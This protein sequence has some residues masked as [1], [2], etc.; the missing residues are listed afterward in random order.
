MEERTNLLL[1]MG[2]SPSQ[3]ESLMAG[4]INQR[5][6]HPATESRLSPL[7]Q[8]Q[9][10]HPITCQIIRPQSFQTTQANLLGQVPPH[11]RKQYIVPCSPSLTPSK[12]SVPILP[13]ALLF[14]ARLLTLH[15]LLV[16]VPRIRGRNLIVLL[17]LY[18]GWHRRS[19][20]RFLRDNICPSNSSSSIIQ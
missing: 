13:R 17:H 19:M 5:P 14:R 18:L 6:D 10:T 3:K 20:G 9:T 7:P 8:S 4:H 2:D 11:P 12:P 16:V 15:L 1:M